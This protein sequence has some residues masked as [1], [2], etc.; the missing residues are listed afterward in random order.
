MKNEFE[1]LWSKFASD[2]L[3]EIHLYYLTVAGEK[4][5]NRIAGNIIKMSINLQ[6]YPEIGQ[7][8]PF[9]LGRDKEYRYLLKGNFKIIYTIEK[10]LNQVR[11]IDIFHTSQN[12]EKIKRKK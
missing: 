3:D 10:N 8:E 4:I 12:P 11:I 1:I 9:L 6:N 7:R 5:A 2:Q